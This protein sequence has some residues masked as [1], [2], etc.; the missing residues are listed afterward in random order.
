MGSSPSQAGSRLLKGDQSRVS[1]IF[2]WT[3]TRSCFGIDVKIRYKCAR[4]VARARESRHH[5]NDDED[6]DEDEDE[7]DDEDDDDDDGEWVVGWPK[8]PA[9]WCPHSISREPAIAACFLSLGSANSQLT[10][11]LAD[12]S[13]STSLMEKASLLFALI[14]FF[15]LFPPSLSKT[16]QL[17]R[18]TKVSHRLML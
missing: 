7:D 10:S 5:D 11:C 3:T 8:I 18:S 17:L 2:D 12:V 4:N 14:R 13:N 6:E 9:I 16:I 1:E 15:L